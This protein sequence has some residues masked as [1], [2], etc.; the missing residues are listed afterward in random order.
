M[1]LLPRVSNRLSN[2]SFAIEYLG[3]QYTAEV[4]IVPCRSSIATLVA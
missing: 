1:N 2:F 4:E 3:G